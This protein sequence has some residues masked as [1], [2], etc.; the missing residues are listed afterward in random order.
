MT[1]WASAFASVFANNAV[2]GTLLVPNTF[3]TIQEAIN[4]SNPGIQEI[5]LLL[6]NP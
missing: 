4:A 5:L 3:L 6:I 1:F 2:A